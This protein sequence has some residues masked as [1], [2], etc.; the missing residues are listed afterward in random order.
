MA[1]SLD[2]LPEFTVILVPVRQFGAGNSSPER[3]KPTRPLEVS[4]GW[5]NGTGATGTASMGT[6][7]PGAWGAGNREC[8]RRPGGGLPAVNGHPARQS[9][10]SRHNWPGMARQ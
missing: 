8:G 7:V 9:Q 3:P 5:L 1:C 2:S 10:P 4:A 6:G